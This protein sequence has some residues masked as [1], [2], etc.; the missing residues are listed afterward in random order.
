[1]AALL[2]SLDA[3]VT[4][5]RR[6]GDGKIRNQGGGKKRR[7]D[8]EG[9][10]DGSEAP[11]TTQLARVRAKATSAYEGSSVFLDSLSGFVP[12]HSLLHSHHR[13]RVRFLI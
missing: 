10:R 2:Q 3:R 1:M 12:E 11:T 5:V 8:G 6:G 7:R 9:D 4:D 13:G